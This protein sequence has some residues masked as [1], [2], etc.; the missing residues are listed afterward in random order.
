MRQNGQIEK[1]TKLGILTLE[2]ILFDQ[3]ID[4][5]ITDCSAMGIPKIATQQWL[6]QMSC[7][8]VSEL[9]NSEKKQHLQKASKF[10]GYKNGSFPKTE[11]QSTQIL[12]LPI[13]QHLKKKE[14]IYICKSINKFYS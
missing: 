14:I 5:F 4:E 3:F 7:L 8:A 6:V 11:K 13:N 9:Q 2:T 12:T 1:Q 10:L